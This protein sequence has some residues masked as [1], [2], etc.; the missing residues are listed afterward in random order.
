MEYIKKNLNKIIIVIVLIVIITFGYRYIN[1]KKNVDI[2]E[3]VAGSEDKTARQIIE[4]LNELNNIDIHYDFFKKT[5]EDS[6]NLLSFSELIDFSEKKLQEKDYGKSNPFI[7]NSGAFDFSSLSNG[8]TGTLSEV[9]GSVNVLKP[10]QTDGN[11]QNNTTNQNQTT[12]S[13]NEVYEANQ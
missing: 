8:N 5:Y 6:E 4:T 10:V 12:S 13:E 1:E 7:K 11:S 9:E 2:T 3:K